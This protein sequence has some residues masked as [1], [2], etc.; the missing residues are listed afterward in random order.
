MKEERF[1]TMSHQVLRQHG[2]SAGSTWP[3]SWSAA[4]ERT[5]WSF[6]LV[7]FGGFFFS[8]IAIGTA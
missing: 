1:R 5:F 4:A 2:Q 3:W 7:Q 6:C 8:I